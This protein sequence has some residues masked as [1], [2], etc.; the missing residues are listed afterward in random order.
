MQKQFESD[1]G[2]CRKMKL[3]KSQIKYIQEAEELR[4]FFNVI[5]TIKQGVDEN[6]D[7]DCDLEKIMH[8][9]GD[10]CPTD[11]FDD[12]LAKNEDQLNEIISYVTED[13]R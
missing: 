8:S 6:L 11:T 1:D 7:R 5:T 12:F 2:T 4:D 3:G 13:L 10:I 9:I